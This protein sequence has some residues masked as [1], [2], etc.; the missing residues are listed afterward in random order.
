MAKKSAKDKAKVEK[1]EKKL[2]SDKELVEYRRKIY[3]M[4]METLIK[5]RERQQYLK[6]NKSKSKDGVTD[7]LGT[8]EQIKQEDQNK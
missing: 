2:V 6:K 5:I 3:Q 7:N 1:K 8:E 4:D